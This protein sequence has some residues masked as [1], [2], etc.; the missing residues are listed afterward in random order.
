M[1]KNRE[2]YI[3]RRAKSQ[4]KKT[5]K[6][7]TKK[8]DPDK[9]M[10]QFNIL[11]VIAFF[12]SCLYIL[13]TFHFLDLSVFQFFQLYFLFIAL[14]FMVSVKKYRKKLDMSMYEYILF[15]FMALAP[16]FICSIFFING[17]Y[18][19]NQYSERYKIIDSKHS[20]IESIYYLKNDQYK[21]KEFIRT[22]SQKDDAIVSGS[23]Y[24]TIHFTQGLLGI[25]KINRKLVE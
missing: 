5:K 24:L 7:K 17:A 21:D 16:L 22:I 20:E 6:I 10:D 1:N 2:R 18:D 8:E 25:R 9:T 12:L 4:A 11:M 14:G 23:D 13:N 3:E 15:N 19:L